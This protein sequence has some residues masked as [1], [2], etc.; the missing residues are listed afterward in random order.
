MGEA[1]LDPPPVDFQLGFT[2]AASADAA[3]EAGQGG[4]LSGEIGHQVFQLRQLDLQFAFSTVG[5]L[6]ED[7]QDEHG[8]VD[9]PELSTFSDGAALAGCQALIEDEQ[10]GAHLQAAHDDLI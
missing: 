4:T 2:G 5:V 9:D 10:V 1:I 6:G 7:V 3:G 8:A